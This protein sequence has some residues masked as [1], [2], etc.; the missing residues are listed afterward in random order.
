VPR[1]TPL[2]KM[3]WGWFGHSRLSWAWFRPPHMASL[4]VAEPP[5][6][7]LGVVWPPPQGQKEKK[8]NRPRVWPLGWFRKGLTDKSL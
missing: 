2:R 3:P 7:P 8:K 6:W 4:G 5:P 1:A